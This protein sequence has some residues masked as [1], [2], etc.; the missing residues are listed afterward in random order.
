MMKLDIKHWQ[1]LTS[2]VQQGTQAKAAQRLGLTQSALSHRLAEVER[3]L[4]YPVFHRK[5]RL[6][7]L[8]RA[9]ESLISTA[10]RTLPLLAEAEKRFIALSKGQVA[11]IKLGVAHYSCY[12]WVANYIQSL[13]AKEN[14]F[15]LDFVTAS[16]QKPIETLYN[17]EADILLYPGQYQ[18]NHIDNQHL[19]DDELVLVMP[20][21][22][23]L[24]NH[25]CIYAP[26]LQ[27]ETFLTYS[28]D[29]TPGFEFERFFKPADAIPENLQVIGLTDAIVEL[30]SAGQGVSILSHWATSTAVAQERVKTRR[31]GKGLTLPW[32]LL[33]R[34]TDRGSSEIDSAKASLLSYFSTLELD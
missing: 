2:I 29:K 8:T 12:H 7:H 18:D 11:Q 5:G 33:T 31:L 23:P 13:T 34:V 1:L 25:P 20:N 9:G 17:G 4:G 32:S 3:R 16:I 19:F 14:T 28:L 15:Q 22:H 26:D 21:Q 10:E 30:V 24:S 6:L 27:G